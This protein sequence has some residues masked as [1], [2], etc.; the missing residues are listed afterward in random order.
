MTDS[1]QQPP[2]RELH[3]HLP[4][5]GNRRR[6]LPWA[7]PVA[8][9]ACIAAGVMAPR[10]FAANPHPHLP[11]KSA[12]QLIAAVDAAS[13]QALSGT[14]RTSAHLGL[15]QLPDN[16]S[17][18][19]NGLTSLLTGTN[20]VRVWVA[21][22]EQQRVA[23]LGDASE[24]DAIHNGHDLWTWNSAAQSV[25][26]ATLSADQATSSAP[27]SPAQELTPM[28]QARQLLRNLTASTSVTVGQTQR[29]AGRPAYLLTLTPRSTQTL[30]G[31]AQI[32]IDSTT[33]VPLGVWL[34]PRGSSTAAL[35]T[36]FTSVSFRKPAASTFTFAPPRGASVT[37]KKISAIQSQ[38]DTHAAHAHSGHSDPT[39]HGAGW[40]SVVEFPSGSVTD[41]STPSASPTHSGSSGS[42]LTEV[43]NPVAGGRLLTTSLLSVMVA[44]DG[45]VFVGAVPGSAL[46]A[47]A[48]S[49]AP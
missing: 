42:L 32:A 25:L 44:D 12:T 46:Q 24:M 2:E 15:P 18:G 27:A 45:R 37:E 36:E 1:P 47:L 20:T 4:R 8:V 31:R 39:L 29:V 17:G 21:G 33:S 11:A 23:L 5:L 9:G 35:S 49:A 7:A 34:F 10:A 13:V 43:T 14:L 28:Q 16:V 22:P 3:A 19:P 40:T 38:A 6:W 30:V 48:A 26:H 41:A